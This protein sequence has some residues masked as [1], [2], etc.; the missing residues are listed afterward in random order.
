MI[1]HV[2]RHVVRQ[3]RRQHEGHVVADVVVGAVL[4]LGVTLAVGVVDVLDLLFELGRRG[5][6]VLHTGRDR[7]C[8]LLLFE[9][10]LAAD[11]FAGQAGQHRF[12]V[13]A[14]PRDGVVGL[15]LEDH[16]LHEPVARRGHLGLGQAVGAVVQALE[17]ELVGLVGSL[18]RNGLPA[19]V[20]QLLL[21]LELRA[22][23][24]F[25]LRV[26]LV[27]VHL[28]GEHD[29]G[30]LGGILRLVDGLAG[31]IHIRVG[32]VGQLARV[33]VALAA[34]LGLVIQGRGEIHHN[35]LAVQVFG[36]L[37]AFF[38]VPFQL[39][40]EGMLVFSDRQHVFGYGYRLT[41][42]FHALNAVEVQAFFHRIMEDNVV[43]QVVG[44]VVRQRRGQLEGHF[45][46]DVIVGRILP[47]AI[48]R[49]T[50]IAVV[51]IHDLLLELRL[52]G[53]GILHAGGQA[54]RSLVRLKHDCAGGDGAGQARQHIPAG[55]I[56]PGTRLVIL[57]VHVPLLIVGRG[58]GEGNRVRA[59]ELAARGRLGLGQF[60]L[61]IV[62]A[63]EHELGLALGEDAVERNLHLLAAQQHL[64]QLELRAGQGELV[65]AHND[66]LVHLHL[67]GEGDHGIPG[68]LALVFGGLALVIHAGG[69]AVL[70]PGPVDV[71]QLAANLGVLV[72]R[73]GEEHLDIGAVQF[74]FDRLA[75]PGDGQVEAVLVPGD[76]IIIALIQG[77]SAHLHRVD[78]LEGQARIHLIVE[79]D[80]VLGVIGHVVR[81]R[82]GQLEGHFVA[83]V[84]V[85]GILPI[86][87]LAVGVVD[88]LD[89][90]L[91]GRL[92][93]R[94]VLHGRGD[95]AGILVGRQRQ[96]A[97]GLLATQPVQHLAAL[98]GNARVAVHVP[99]A[100]MDRGHC[101]GDGIDAL[102]ARRG[103]GLGQHILAV[104]QALEGELVIHLGQDIVGLQDLT[105]VV[106]DL[107]QLERRVVKGFV[108]F[109]YLADIQLIGEHDHSVPVCGFLLF[110][111]GCSIVVVSADSAVFQLHLI[112]VAVAAD[113][114]IVVQ[115]R[116]EQHLHLRA[117]QIVGDRVFRALAEVDGKVEV[118]TR[119]CQQ[120]GHFF[121]LH[122]DAADLF[123]GQAFLHHIVEG[124]VVPGEVGDVVGQLRGQAEGHGIADVVVGGI[125]P[126]TLRGVGRIVDVRHLLFEG[127]LLHGRIGDGEALHL[128]G[129]ADHGLLLDGILD[130]HRVFAFRLFGQSAEAEVPH[131]VGVHGHIRSFEGP[132]GHQGPGAA[133]GLVQAD[134]DGPGRAAVGPGLGAVN[135][136]QA[137]LVGVGGRL[138]RGTLG[139]AGDGAGGRAG[140]FGFG[141]GGF[142]GGLVAVHCRLGHGV[143]GAVGQLQEGDALVVLQHDGG[144]ACG[145]G[146]DLLAIKIALG[147]YIYAVDLITRRNHI[148]LIIAGQG[149]IVLVG[150]GD[151]ELEIAG[152]LYRVR[153][154][155]DHF[156]DLQLA[157]GVL[158]IAEYQAGLVGR[159]D[160]AVS[161][162]TVAIADI[163]LMFRLIVIAGIEQVNILQP[164]AVPGLAI[165]SDR[166]SDLEVGSDG[167]AVNDLLHAADFAGRLGIP[168]CVCTLADG[169][170][171]H[172]LAGHG[173][174][175]HAAPSFSIGRE[176]LAAE[177]AGH[178]NLLTILQL[179]QFHSEA[180][181]IR[182]REGIAGN[183]LDDVQLTIAVAGVGDRRDGITGDLRIVNASG[184]AV[185]Q[186]CD[187]AFGLG[188][189]AAI[190]NGL[191]VVGLGVIILLH[192]VGRARGQAIHVQGGCLCDGDKLRRN[193]GVRLLV[194][195]Y[196]Y[197]GIV[198][199]GVRHTV[200]EGQIERLVAHL[201]CDRLRVGVVVQLDLDGEPA[202]LVRVVAS[203]HLLNLQ[204]A[205]AIPGVGHGDRLGLLRHDRMSIVRIGYLLG[206]AA[207]IHRGMSILA[208]CF[209]QSL[210][211]RID[212][213][214][215]ESVDGLALAIGQPD[216]R[217]ASLVKFNIIRSRI[218]R[219]GILL[220][221]V[222][223]GH[224]VAAFRQ[225]DRDGEL[226]GLI[227]LV[228]PHMLG[229]HHRARGPTVGHDSL[230]G[231]IRVIR[232]FRRHDLARLAF[233]DSDIFA[234]IVLG[235]N[236]L[237][238]IGHAHRD[239]FD[240]P[241]ITVAQLTV[242][243][244]VDAAA[245]FLGKG[246]A[247]IDQLG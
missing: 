228:A 126:A 182:I 124:D 136:G 184:L 113:N 129:E 63:L 202:L 21:Q 150:Q 174:G 173:E 118:V 29:H 60:V 219:H 93:G 28:V 67:V 199:A 105:A 135:A 62:Q 175:L 23:Q 190:D 217:L 2:V 156:A 109:I 186:V 128:G 97:G 50:G 42:D 22:L 116:G 16:G 221:T 78:L 9:G 108:V 66:H 122:G 95:D 84:V 164:V 131:A 187:G 205:V 133:H 206:I 148:H 198:L 142:D 7:I 176:N 241:G 166:L 147:G 213:A 34:Q 27:H 218:A 53:L 99:H 125:L 57:I 70:Q 85:G 102:V 17:G 91:Q 15:D 6:R 5:R 31:G 115:L 51:D 172:L 236:F 244:L 171:L 191:A 65:A 230:I 204:R 56:D 155:L 72:Q 89:L 90:L 134:L 25:S 159:D 215:L 149:L 197:L 132:G 151:G 216:D 152:L 103:P 86:R 12:A 92:L 238:G 139:I 222:S 64:L 165:V 157:E 82:S 87:L 121:A 146:N 30:V 61:A 153:D 75:L 207:V 154:I 81:Q 83:D 183:Q 59:H 48:G 240:R 140:G 33:E 101:E 231:S 169:A 234:L 54:A 239:A 200:F 58:H 35:V 210:I 160:P 144:Y 226:H 46:A 145:E 117:V 96:H 3:L 49:V 40:V 214:H 98:G 106:G 114:G 162:L 13:R 141:A 143:L 39:Q 170:F 44:H 11:L 36:D 180:E 20:N 167:Y 188:H 195:R 211:N 127:R 161:L 19:A 32:A 41:I 80:V 168:V 130:S 243:R 178:G 55:G 24:G 43:G 74:G 14:V 112:D 225:H 37:L 71:A 181:G 120:I 201:G 88:I 163:E 189:V 233:N 227:A 245:V 69:V 177:G 193:V 68:G 232:F 158:H 100:G 179:P 212:G 8:R 209:G 235:Q 224:R 137:V 229:N 18:F 107:L 242:N 77:L 246:H 52:L 1:L 192:G 237:D 138:Q 79:G 196:T 94:R 47:L 76:G 4:G 194:H 45:V 10:D 38:T 203:G 110:L 104:V 123:E 119:L 73:G 185:D 247:V 26:H 111:H 223:P 208:D 220:A